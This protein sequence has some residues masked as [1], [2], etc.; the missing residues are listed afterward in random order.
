MQVRKAEKL[1]I[2]MV[3][4]KFVETCI[5]KGVLLDA[6]D[7]P[8]Y[9]NQK[10]AQGGHEPGDRRATIKNNHAGDDRKRKLPSVPSIQAAQKKVRGLETLEVEECDVPWMESLRQQ[11]LQWEKDC[12]NWTKYP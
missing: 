5:Q 8:A 11:Q 3:N 7:F 10:N 9:Q 12:P 1:G 6:A 4:Q 2:P